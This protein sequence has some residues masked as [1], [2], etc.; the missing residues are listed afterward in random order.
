MANGFAIDIGNEGAAYEQGVNMPNYSSSAAAVEGLTSLGQGVFNVLDAMDAA[1]RAAAPTQSEKDKQAFGLLSKGIDELKGLNPLQK[2]TGLT[3]LL[4]SYFNAGNEIGEAEARL[5]KLKVG[6]DVDSLRMNPQEAAIQENLDKILSNP[7][8][9]YNAREALVKEGKPFSE[10]QVVNKAYQTLIQ[11]EAASLY[12]S[13]AK[14]IDKK[15]YYDSFLPHAE[16]IFDDL[17]NRASYFMDVEIEGG[18]I[19]PE[20][21]SQLRGVYEKARAS[22]TRPPSVSVEEYSTIQNRIDAM[23]RI[24]TAIQKYDQNTLDKMKADRIRVNTLTIM[25]IA[26]EIGLDPVTENAL[27]SGDLDLSV[28]LGPDLP[29]I[30]KT[31]AEASVEDL[32]YSDLNPPESSEVSTVDSTVD[33]AVDSAVDKEK[34]QPITAPTVDN[35]H[36]IEEVEKAE[37][38]SDNSRKDAIFFSVIQRISNVTPKSMEQPEL[39]ENFFTGIGQATVNI[40]TSPKLFKNETMTQVYNDETYKKIEAAMRLDPEKAKIAKDRLIDGLL[41]QFNIASTAISGSSQSSFFKISGLGEVEYDLESRVDTGQIRMDKQVV[42][43]VKGFASKYYNGNVTEMI[44]DRAVRL[45]TFERTQ[46]ENAGFNLRVAFQDY[47]KILKNSEGLRFYVNNMKKLGVPTEEIESM[48][49]KPIEA[50]DSA[51]TGT[52][53]NPWQIVWSDNT[54]AD[55]KLFASLERGEYYTDINGDVRIKD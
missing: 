49:I 47:R 31:L 44:A 28:A 42:P 48:L 16:S 17:V 25:K 14:T 11:V 26:K 41:A 39:R 55:E 46:I 27:L 3:S 40:S 34:V 51:A 19:S 32:V 2:R 22:F 6:I 15:Q 54:D 45:D 30:L 18:N 50:G 37:D 10:E 21:L 7:S 35:L 33:S 5:I 8:A 9:L 12:I 43:L 36:A 53:K 24:L 38:R 4:T 29:K 1:K 52:L 13:N 20:S 23:D